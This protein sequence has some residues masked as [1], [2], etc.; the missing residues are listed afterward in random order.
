MRA[1]PR[2]PFHDASAFLI[3]VNC[4]LHLEACRTTACWLSFPLV[5]SNSSLRAADLDGKVVSWDEHEDSVY[6]MAWS[7]ADPWLLASLSFDGRVTV[8][9]VPKNIKYKILI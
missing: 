1:S 7:A 8:H 9:R 4:G 3:A 6:S 2:L 5:R